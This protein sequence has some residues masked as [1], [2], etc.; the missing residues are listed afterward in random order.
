M[1]VLEGTVGAFAQDMIARFPN[2]AADR[3]LLWSNAFFVLGFSDR[4][5]TW[6][7][8]AEAITLM[9]NPISNHGRFHH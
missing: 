5:L 1:I 3:A 6:L 8:V 4:S 7:K 9:A 2:D